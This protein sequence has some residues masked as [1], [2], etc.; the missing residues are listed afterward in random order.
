M[1]NELSLLEVVKD[2][3]KQQDSPDRRRELQRLEDEN[4]TLRRDLEDANAEKDR[5]TRTVKNLQTTLNPMY[6]ALRA[7]FGEIELAVGEEAGGASVPGGSQ[8]VV[9]DPRWQ[10]FKTSF[11]GVGAEIIDALQVHN[12]M[13]LLQLAKLLR[14]DYK[15][16]A[17]TAL[18]LREAGA[19]TYSPRTPLSLKR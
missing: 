18:R 4:R 2:S 16:I 17:R 6:R 19:I 10:S 7:L 5:L 1:A 13:T 8:P 14:H 12:E 15:T 11:P 9:N 3:A